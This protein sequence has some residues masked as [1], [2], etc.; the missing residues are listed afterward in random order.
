M[1]SDEVL[2]CLRE[3]DDDNEFDDPIHQKSIENHVT[4]LDYLYSNLSHY[5]ES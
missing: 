3:E 4:C 2:G 5:I 1:T